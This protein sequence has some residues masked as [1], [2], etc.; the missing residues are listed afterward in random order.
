MSQMLIYMRWMS[1]LELLLIALLL[2]LLVRRSLFRTYPYFCL[3]LGSEILARVTFLLFPLRTRY[4][5]FY[6]GYTPLQWVIGILVVYELYANILTDYPGIVSAGRWVIGGTFL[7]AVLISLA[8][9]GYDWNLSG[10]SFPKIFYYTYA[11]RGIKTAVVLFL[12][13][14]TVFLRWFPA[15]LDRN[16]HVHG[17]ILFIYNLIAAAS[18]MIQ[19]IK[20]AEFTDNANLAISLGNCLCLLGWMWQLSPMQRP[21]RVTYRKIDPLD[22]ERILAKLR[23]INDT[24]VG[25]SKDKSGD[26]E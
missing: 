11:S 24:L 6:F 13:G 18:L 1:G 7:I 17:L 3:Y 2:V 14:M 4:A 25:A 5:E 26:R 8:S 21:K 15:P 10:Q 9:G 12:F 22:E 16:V 23:S 20:G 19:N